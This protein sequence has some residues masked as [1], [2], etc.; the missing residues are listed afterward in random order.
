M[1]WVQVGHVKWM[2]QRFFPLENRNC[3]IKAPPP[4]PPPYAFRPMMMLKTPLISMYYH[5][6]TPASYTCLD[7]ALRLLSPFMP[8]LSEELFQRLP[9][10]QGDA[11]PSVT[12]APFPEQV[13]VCVAVQ[14]NN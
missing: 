1:L 3:V 14:S 6:L 11:F 4:P 2:P 5:S 13:C 7:T 10:R 8:F 9:R 12:V